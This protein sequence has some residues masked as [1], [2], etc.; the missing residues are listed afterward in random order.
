MISLQLG[1]EVCTQ[2]QTIVIT[3]TVNGL[4]WGWLPSC[5]Q[6]KSGMEQPNAYPTTLVITTSPKIERNSERRFLER[7]DYDDLFVFT[8][9]AQMTDDSFTRNSPFIK[10]VIKGFI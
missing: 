10:R 8:L 2:H 5:H 3:Q 6:G 1:K 7:N 4:F 9:Q